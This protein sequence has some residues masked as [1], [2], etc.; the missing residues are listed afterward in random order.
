MHTTSRPHQGQKI[1][2]EGNLV[3]V[4][5]GDIMNGVGMDCGRRQDAD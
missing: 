4:R 5:A 1:Y 2:V 3:G